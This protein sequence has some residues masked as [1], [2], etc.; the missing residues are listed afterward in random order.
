M[1]FVIAPAAA[2]VLIPLACVGWNTGQPKHTMKPWAERLL[3]GMGAMCA[4]IALVAGAS[5]AAQLLGGTGLVL[6]CLLFAL[7][8]FSRLPDQRPAAVVGEVAPDFALSDAEG[9]T[10]RLADY[11][12]S[13]LVLKFYRGCWCPYCVRDLHEWEAVTGD[14][15]ARNIN[16][17]AISPDRIDEMRAFKHGS[18]LTMTLLADPENQVIR[19]YNLQNRNFTPKRGPFRE[20]VIPTT[21][22]IDGEGVVRFIDQAT[23]FRA[24]K[25]FKTTLEQIGRILLAG[26]HDAGAAPPDGRP[27]PRDQLSSIVS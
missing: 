26:D 16:V 4:V 17:V 18:G 2:S 15:L 12:G 25:P 24:R 10:R 3:T 8:F 1:S 19:R 27:A 6:S 20:L 7:T 13:W 23:D 5:L 22:L 14:L 21:L 11:A 9:H